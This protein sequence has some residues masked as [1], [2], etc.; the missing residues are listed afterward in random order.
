[1]RV[2]VRVSGTANDVCCDK[3]FACAMP[4]AASAAMVGERRR[5]S[6]DVNPR[7][8]RGI[9]QR[10][11]PAHFDSQIAHKLDLVIWKHEMAGLVLRVE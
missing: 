1:M 5:R 8:Y 4:R 10:S 11:V 9:L 2:R 7:G 6:G 3:N